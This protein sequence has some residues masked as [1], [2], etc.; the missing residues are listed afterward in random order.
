MK[1]RLSVGSGIAALC[2]CVSLCMLTVG[3]GR[4]AKEEEPAPQP[5][6]TKHAPPAVQ[7]GQ[8]ILPLGTESKPGDDAPYVVDI[9][10]T[11]LT[12]SELDAVVSRS[13]ALQ[14]KKN[15]KMT[16]KN[17]ANMQFNIE[18]SITKIF[19]TRTLL[20]HEAK[21]RKVLADPEDVGK[22]I[23]QMKAAVPKGKTFQDVLLEY[24]K[25]ETTLRD[26]LERDL[27][28]TKL[29]ELITSHVA[30]PSQED[31]DDLYE[32]TKATLGRAKARHILV[33]CEKGAS[34][35][36]HATKK[37]GAEALRKQLLD[38]ADFAELAN[39]H[40][41]CPSGKQSGGDLPPFERGKMAQEFEKAAFEQ[42]IGEIGPIVQTKFGYHIVEVQKRIEPSEEEL[43]LLKKQTSSY[44]TKKRRKPVIEEFL[45]TL[46]DSATITY[47]ER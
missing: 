44:L 33:K 17:R 4:R 15:P 31:I 42:E 22:M 38:G 24:G 1:N 19:L 16:E 26:G 21:R 13:L 8:A 32:K 20:L 40:S 37:K 14:V 3:C 43:E 6:V 27:C 28:I 7:P 2:I 30:E 10:G 9:D 41:D 46:G 5:S 47:P 12:K 36:M 45:A 35:A 23:A 11:R 39:A 34:A 25:T 29:L 18:Q